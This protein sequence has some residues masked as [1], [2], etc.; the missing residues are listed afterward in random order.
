M[1]K[2]VPLEL[3]R[4]IMEWEEPRGRWTGLVLL[5]VNREA[6]SLG[7]WAAF[8]THAG[9]SWV[10]VF[11]VRCPV[12]RWPQWMRDRI[13]ASFL[14]DQ[15]LLQRCDA[16]NLLQ[17]AVAADDV[18]LLPPLLAGFA[19]A[20]PPTPS[21]LSSTL[22][23]ALQNR[24]M[25]CVWWLHEHAGVAN[26]ELLAEASATPLFA[27]VQ[28]RLGRSKRAR[29]ELPVRTA[30]EAAVFHDNAKAFARL[31]DVHRLPLFKLGDLF[32][33][34]GAG[35]A[36]AAFEARQ[37][38]FVAADEYG[39]HLH[40]LTP[41][42]ATRFL[43]TCNLRRSHLVQ[44]AAACASTEVLIAA[45]ERWPQA[46]H[47][48]VALAALVERCT[49]RASFAHLMH[50][51]AADQWVV[52][53]F[54][55]SVA[56]HRAPQLGAFDDLVRMYGE[57]LK[58]RRAWESVRMDALATAGGYPAVLWAHQHHCLWPL[59]YY[60]WVVV[61]EELVPGAVL[62]HV[63][64]LH[65]T[66]HDLQATIARGD[67]ERVAWMLQHLA[68]SEKPL[69]PEDTVRMWSSAIWSNSLACVKV[70]VHSCPLAS[71]NA[72]KLVRE[73]LDLNRNGPKHAD[74]EHF[75]LTRVANS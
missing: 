65:Y 55:W 59:H 73:L 20:G 66:T 75:L 50:T 63:S 47:N 53:A 32:Y 30:L 45:L 33:A 5:Q 16:W 26:A 9:R 41:R 12:V 58:S 43:S 22:R 34:L 28:K 74:I 44:A 10:A 29:S 67:P 25:R 40:H 27:T 48:N 68:A 19:V 54:N 2:R 17:Q 38:E 11:A 18:E 42:Q 71:A 31:L 39:L 72:S 56:I 51:M 13:D 4:Y 37:E 52:E 62:D 36:Q 60:R 8:H 70:V 3:W 6:E 35:C 14:G 64:Q 46:A 21:H 15:K 7:H 61:A 69:V 24:A 49:T 1:F 23:C 57:Q